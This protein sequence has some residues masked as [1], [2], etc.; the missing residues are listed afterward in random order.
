MRDRDRAG[1]PLSRPRPTATNAWSV[2]DSGS[3]PSALTAERRT[4]D[5]SRGRVGGPAVL[6][7]ACGAIATGAATILPQPSGLEL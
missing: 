7:S 4:Y 1:K 2:A 3:A 6:S 5:L